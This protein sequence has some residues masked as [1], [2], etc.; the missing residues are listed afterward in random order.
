LGGKESELSPNAPL[1]S[2]SLNL[3][4]SVQEKALK[5]SKLKREA[6]LSTESS[7]SQDPRTLKPRANR[8][9]ENPRARRIKAT[10]RAK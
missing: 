8:G 3:P 6:K 9:K 7:R 10:P 1:S 2:I 5:V 4:K